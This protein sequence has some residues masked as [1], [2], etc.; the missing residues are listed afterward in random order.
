VPLDPPVPASLPDDFKL[1]WGFLAFGMCKAGKLILSKQM[2]PTQL[3]GLTRG[4]ADYFAS[5]AYALPLALSRLGASA[6]VYRR[7]FRAMDVVL[8]PVTTEAPP[9][10]GWLNPSVPFDTLFDRIARYTA[11]TPLNNATGSPAIALPVGLSANGLP[12]G[13]HF[14]ATHGDERTLIE[15]AYTL[16]AELG[17]TGIESAC[18]S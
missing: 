15:L 17:F 3:D 18:P 6:Y 14:S 16:E 13:V 12:I 7:A 11:F 5:R 4:L 9:K 1:Y 10:L 2:Q 8:S